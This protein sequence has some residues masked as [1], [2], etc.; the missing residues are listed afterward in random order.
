MEK[1]PNLEIHYNRTDAILSELDVYVPSLKLAFELN[2]IY[3]YEP[4]HGIPK[5]LSTQNNDNRK[6][7]ACLERGI[8]LCIMDVS[9]IKHFTEPRGVKFLKIIEGIIDSKK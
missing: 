5:L 9:A 7:Q 8:E 6:Y 3:H 2:G 1:Y 4:I